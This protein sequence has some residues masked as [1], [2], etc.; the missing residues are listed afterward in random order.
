MCK[1]EFFDYFS[2]EVYESLHQFYEL[3]ALLEK[4]Y[5]KTYKDLLSLRVLII[6]LL[7]LFRFPLSETFILI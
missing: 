4:S 5:L 1:Y 3:S 6:N 7:F 2:K